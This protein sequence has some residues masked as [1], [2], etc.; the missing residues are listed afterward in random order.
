[1]RVARLMFTSPTQAFAA[2]KEKPVFALPMILVIVCAVAATVVYYSKVDIAWLQDQL[3]AQMKNLNA[4]QQ[5]MVAGRMTRTVLLW[6][7]VISTPIGL[8]IGMVIGAVYFLVVGQITKVRYSF[9]HWFAFCW[10]ATTPQVVGSII[11]ILIVMVSSTTQM[12]TG[13]LQPLSLNELVFHKNLG[14]PGYT[15]LASIGLVQIASLFLTYIGIKAWSGRSTAFC[16]LFT[17]VPTVVIYG[18]WALFAFR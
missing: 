10:W 2:L 6:T 4:D 13:S 14:E 18:V 3:L 17:L 8:T 11:A 12:G 7:S 16:L 1:M 15:W 9:N 5:K